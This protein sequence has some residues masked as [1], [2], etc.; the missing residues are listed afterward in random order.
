MTGKH[1]AQLRD[2]EPLL[3]RPLT[4]AV[5]GAHDDAARP[6]HYVPAWLAAHGH[7]ILPVNPRLVGRH[8][9]GAPVRGTLAELDEPVDVVDVFR[10]REDV[11]AHVGDILAMRHRP[12]VV[13][14]QSGID[15]PEACAT[16]R[17]AGIDTVADRCML[18][19]GR[20]LGL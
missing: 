18:A 14:L 6:A 12:G 1:L 2:V 16:L 11:P 20:A 5:L 10:R 13:W 19:D 15:H 8:V 9:L 7:R 17:A 4:V 3:R